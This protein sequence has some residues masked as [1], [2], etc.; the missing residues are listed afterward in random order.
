M[1]L[2]I[3]RYGELTRDELYSIV[4]LRIDVF[5][6]EQSCPY[7]ELD[8]LDQDAV[9]VWIED[10]GEIQAYLR[11][12]D[13]GAESEHVSIG[14]VVATKRRSG[15]GTRVLKEGIRAAKQYFGADSVYL[16]AQTYAREFY[17]KQGFEQISEPFM[18]DGIEHIKMLKI[19]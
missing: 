9:H 1:T 16:E 17:E 2:N 13:R 12:M 18:L 19:I 15:L 7:P 10:G 5:V 4:K 8:G 6:V 11:V 3:K 14:R